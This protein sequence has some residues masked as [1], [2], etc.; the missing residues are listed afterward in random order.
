MNPL[1]SPPEVGA[2][3]LQ[4]G[5]GT[6]EPWG[7]VSSL[8]SHNCFRI[9]FQNINGFNNHP[10]IKIHSL[11]QH[12]SD[13]QI[14]AFGA[15]E[16]NTNWTRT[17]SLYEQTLGLFESRRV[18][19]SHLTAQSFPQAYQPGG[20]FIL[21]RDQLANRS[22]TSSNDPRRL[23]RWASLSFR[24]RDSVIFRFVV[25]Y[26]PVKAP[27]ATTAYGQQSTALSL[28]GI[29]NCPRVQLL[30]DLS[31]QLTTWLSSGERIVLAVDF[32]A[33]IRGNE[34][35]QFFA[36]F[37]MREALIQRH[38]PGPPTYVHS[39]SGHA[40]DGLYCTSALGST[41]RGGYF[42]MGVGIYKADHR[43][44][45]IDIP[46]TA[47]LGSSIPAFVRPIA[48]RLRCHD[49]RIVQRYNNFV[50]EAYQSKPEFLDVVQH[51]DTPGVVTDST[52]RKYDAMDYWRTTTLLKAE[53]Y[54]RKL[55]M[56]G[57]PYSPQ[58]TV[59]MKSIILWKH[60]LSRVK[61][62]KFS[63][64]YIQ[65]L[66]RETGTT[67]PAISVLT[68]EY[69]QLQLKSSY[70]QYFS[71]KQDASRRRVTFLE[72]L[73]AAHAQSNQRSVANNLQNLMQ[74][75]MTRNS[76]RRVRAILQ[77]QQPQGLDFVIG[78]DGVACHDKEGM[79]QL[80]SVE[81]TQRF[82][83]TADT[84]FMSSPTLL[85]DFGFC[86][87]GP[88][89]DAVLSGE[90]V[91]P[92]DLP[93]GVRLFLQHVKRPAD[94][95]INI[96]SSIPTHVFSSAFQAARETT[97]S[98]FS[99]L[100]YGHYKALFQHTELSEVE[101]TWI[102]APFK[103]GF[104]SKRSRVGIDVM[105]EKKPGVRNVDKLRAILLFEADFNST[106]K[107]L[108][109]QL[110]YNAEKWLAPEQY[111]SRSRHSAICQALNKRLTLDYIRV[112]HLPS[113]W[114][115]TDAKSNYDRIVHTPAS[116]ALQR[117]GLSKEACKC[118][119]QTVGRMRHVIRTSLGDSHGGY[120]S[121]DMP[122]QG[123]GQGNGMGPAIWAILSSVL[124]DAM[125][126]SG[127]GY[128]VTA[129]I[130]GKSTHLIGG[131]FV[132][133]LDLIST[134]D[135]SL[136]HE[137]DIQEAQRG[138]DLWEEL[139]RATGGAIEP[140][141]SELYYI[142]F[143]WTNG[144]AHLRP[145]DPVEVSLSCLDHNQVRRQLNV[146]Q[147][148][149]A[150][151]T[152][153][154]WL[155]PDGSEEGSARELRSLAEVC[156]DQIRLL[157]R[158]N[159]KDVWRAIMTRFLKRIQYQLLTSTLTEEQCTTI[160]VPL[161][162]AALSA[163]GVSRKFPRA[164]VYGP[165]DC[166]GLGVPNL[167]TMQ[168]L[169]HLEC[170]L[171][172]NTDV[173]RHMLTTA[174]ESSLVETGLPG[175]LFLHPFYP[176]TTRTWATFT[177]EF[178]RHLLLDVNEGTEGPP[179]L[180]E[181]DAYL[182][183][184]FISSG[185]YTNS[186]LGH[187]NRCR[188]YLRVYSRSDITEGNGVI[189]ARWAWTGDL[190]QRLRPQRLKWPYQ[191]RPGKTSWTL[192]RKA[193]TKCI[194]GDPNLLPLGPWT[195][196]DH[197]WWYSPSTGRLYSDDSSYERWVANRYRYSLPLVPGTL[198]LDAQPATVFRR[199]MGV[200]ELEGS[201]PYFPPATLPLCPSL[202]AHAQASPPSLQWALHNLVC[203]D[204][205]ETVTIAI[206]DGSC[207]LVSDGSFQEGL[208]TAA[209]CITPGWLDET[210]CI[211]GCCIVPGRVQS[212]FRAE[213]GGMYAALRA[214]LLLV[215]RAQLT[216]GAIQL[217]CDGQAALNRIRNGRMD[218]KGSNFDLVT[219]ILTCLNQLKGANIQVELTY[220]R[221]H[222]DESCR[223][224]PLTLLELLNVRADAQA[225]EFNRASR[226][227]GIK[228]MDGEILGEI[229]PVW[230]TVPDRGRIKIYNDLVSTIHREFHAYN[231]RVYWKEKGTIINDAEVD[232]DILKRTNATRTIA[233][234]IFTVKRVSGYLG[235]G[236]WL[237][238]W[239]KQ[240]DPSCLL[241]N[242]PNEDIHHVYNCPALNNMW[243]SEVTKIYNWVLDSTQSLRLAEFLRLLLLAYRANGPPPAPHLD[244]DL[245]TL[246]EYQLG[247]GMDSI[248]NGFLSFRW[249]AVVD[250]CTG[251]LSTTSWLAALTSKIYEMGGAVWGQRNTLLFSPE[252][253]RLEAAREAVIAELTL[254]SGGN[255]RVMELMSDAAKP[256]ATSSLL[257]MERWIANVQ[258][259]RAVALPQEERQNRGREIMYRWLLSGRRK[260]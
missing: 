186:Q 26:R 116:L 128:S 194:V 62:R 257:F 58:V 82:L 252:G 234:H 140:T 138:L 156:G 249:R 248:L 153:G 229:G 204:N 45:W 136:F 232:W 181:G 211:D 198:P 121:G 222:Q 228:A 231:L 191:E 185:L 113:V 207:V 152:L 77:G 174:L 202:I 54:C 83:Q 221:G 12:M 260:G 146:R 190:S 247:I 48:R 203:Q 119:F 122:F 51:F 209:F 46:Y 78:P 98:S 242:F 59:A 130:S 101:A 60:I 230:M 175:P 177:W 99:G 129:P 79:F 236:K 176:Y 225:Q 235:V 118:M 112:N 11:F 243:D 87:I 172:S 197:W 96:G 227:Q 237:H 108:A 4:V 165:V 21:A 217:G 123:V 44:L 187:L 25:V 179:L 106:A 244:A 1:G 183:S 143:S 43:C 28:E 137:P 132:D 42:E 205:G 65:R 164:V 109:R 39:P 144:V 66:E 255:Q 224:Q 95:Q 50:Y 30:E 114:I 218:V 88:A 149:E 124:F 127:F 161:I 184:L 38:G 91:I 27:G 215:Q 89:A 16:A 24:G 131:A 180:C 19:T 56:G 64:R 195:S 145:P 105:I 193:L 23:G 240:Q 93:L 76:N 151:K 72:D 216:H 158:L 171:S 70:S 254:G 74:R 250:G 160:M 111:G 61:G 238:R 13:Y 14:D 9:A 219:G 20:V 49:P 196:S 15:A 6:G 5:G 80:L 173:G 33:D 103:W 37:G 150:I 52:A 163:V 31:A 63:V 189:I 90:Y 3:I 135:P 47:A 75:E 188:L 2:H 208:G 167:H 256:T 210:T 212:A 92:Q 120:T 223:S 253:G 213:L 226:L 29:S 8:K 141:K 73:A 182:M 233:Q 134:Y 157:S 201:R 86:G 35:T 148:N 94:I 206:G 34:A 107:I 71:I 139:L 199:R 239:K 258:A 126:S 85:N 40:I 117:M 32:N 97:S 166:Q 100:H 69:A 162:E 10:H 55:N 214:V 241:C 155:A 169:L 245:S 168:G 84:P 192:W 133:D 200:L 67:V 22:F 159:T 68:E 57:V 170:L 125:R 7:D 110:M 220:V 53:K 251:R 17:S 104:S 154:V 81:N 36:N 259:A 18:V 102:H 41:I 246:W 142:D 115:L 178:S 147:P